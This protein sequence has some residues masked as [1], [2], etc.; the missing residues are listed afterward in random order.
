MSDTLF[1]F[2]MM[3]L[4]FWGLYRHIDG[5]FAALN[6]KLLMSEEEKVPG[7]AVLGCSA[8]RVWS[9]GKKFCYIILIDN[10]TLEASNAE[11]NWGLSFEVLVRHE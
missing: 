3:G 8:E 1:L 9:D 6:R 4:F 7:G 10:K 2:V 11:R 5:K